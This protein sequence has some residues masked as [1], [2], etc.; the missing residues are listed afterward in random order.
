MAYRFNLE[1]TKLVPQVLG[2]IKTNHGGHEETD[3]FDTGNAADAQA[4]HEEPEKPCR[5]EALV[6]EAV[7]LGPAQD[8]GKCAAKEHGVEQDETYHDVISISVVD[9]VAYVVGKL[10]VASSYGKS[11]YSCSRKESSG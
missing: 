7:K 4:G 6:L 5:A 9:D 1:V 2:R 11:W 10:V 3:K 8:C